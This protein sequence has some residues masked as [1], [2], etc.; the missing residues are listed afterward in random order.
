MIPERYNDTEVLP[1]YLETSN[2]TIYSHGPVG[3]KCFTDFFKQTGTETTLGYVKP[4]HWAGVSKAYTNKTHILVLRDPI[5]QHR[6]AAWL[7]G[8][9]IHEADKKRHNMFYHTHLA[10]HLTLTKF[11]EFDF[12]I[13]FNKIGKYIFDYQPPAQPTFDGQLMGLEDE[14]DAYNWIKDNKME[15][16]V[17]QWREIIMRGQLETI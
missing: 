1:T 8:M 3:T 4:A 2:L 13:D 14:L 17:S 9:S 15:L 6:H 12:Y 11:A 7:H 5:E 16:K 10:P